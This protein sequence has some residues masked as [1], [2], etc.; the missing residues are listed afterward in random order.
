MEAGI[1]WHCLAKLNKK[2]KKCLEDYNAQYGFVLADFD[3]TAKRHL[4]GKTQS[5]S[6]YLELR[7]DEK[8]NKMGYKDLGFFQLKSCR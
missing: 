6:E 4:H 2:K 1:L 8:N 5:S 3:G 7:Q